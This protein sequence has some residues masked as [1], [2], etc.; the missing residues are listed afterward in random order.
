MHLVL[1]F[2]SS[3]AASGGMVDVHVSRIIFP[4]FSIFLDEWGRA[5]GLAHGHLPSLKIKPLCFAWKQPGGG[6]TTMDNLTSRFKHLIGFYTALMRLYGERV[7]C[8][9]FKMEIDLL[10]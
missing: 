7:N 2:C 4:H 5:E 1:D 8:L 3:D 10:S 9:L 6:K